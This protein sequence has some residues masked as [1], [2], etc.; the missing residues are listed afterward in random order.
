MPRLKIPL[1]S[2]GF[3]STEFRLTVPRRVDVIAL[4]DNGEF[5]IVE[6]K[7]TIED[8]RGDRKW[9]EYLPFCDRFFFAVPEGFPTDILPDDHGLMI[10]DGHGAAIVRPAPLRDMNGTRRRHQTLKFGLAASSRLFAATHTGHL[11]PGRA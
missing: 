5:V 9:Q 10:A 11:S 4:S 8:Y 3:V 2:L 1:P 7:S 6:I